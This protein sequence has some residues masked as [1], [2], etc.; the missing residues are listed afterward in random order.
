MFDEGSTFS[1]RPLAVGSLTTYP[2]F[3]GNRIVLSNLV[4]SIYS[5]ISLLAVLDKYL[6]SSPRTVRCNPFLRKLDADI[7]F[8]NT[9]VSD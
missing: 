1:S 7:F 2:F 4:P 3:S 8:V 5:T 6:Y 9:K